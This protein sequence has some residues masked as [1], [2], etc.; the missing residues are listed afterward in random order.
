MA[1]GGSKL[2]GD[3]GKADRFN[4]TVHSRLKK[5]MALATKKNA[6]GLRDAIKRTL[7]TGLPSWPPL[8]GLTTKA[9]KSSKPLMDYGDLRDAV[10]YVIVTPTTFFVGVPRSAGGKDRTPFVN[11]AAVHEYGATI[12]PRKVRALAIPVSR[13]A[14]ELAKQNRGVRN[15]PGLF[16]PKGT[17]VLALSKGK[18]FEIMFILRKQSVIPPRPFIRPTAQLY[19]PRMARRWREAIRATVKGIRYA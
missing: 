2:T 9:K 10:S 1:R 8:S 6:S 12:K 4:K 5:N 11:I 19:R 3:W 18:G 7:T 13:K 17:K 16:R 14:S 15:I